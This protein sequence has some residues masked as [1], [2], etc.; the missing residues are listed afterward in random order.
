MTEGR[1]RAI[2]RDSG[3]AASLVAGRIP[4]QFIDDR[5]AVSNDTRA[6]RHERDMVRRL[7]RGRGWVAGFPFDAVALGRIGVPTLLLYGTRDAVGDVAIWQRFVDWLPNGRLEVIVGAGH[8]PWFDEP[9][10][11]AAAITQFLATRLEPDLRRRE[12]RRS[13]AP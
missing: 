4:R 3:H 6:M 8:M 7:V 10:R 13:P 1:M 12:P 2:L 5:V 11:V 9:G